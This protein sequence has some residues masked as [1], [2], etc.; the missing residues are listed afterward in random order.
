MEAYRTAHPKDFILL[1]FFSP[2][3]YEIRK[4]YPGADCICY[5]PL[6]FPWNARRF[7]QLTRP[8][9][10]YFVKYEF[11]YFFLTALKRR[12]IP[13]YLFSAIFLKEQP[14]F[15][16]YGGIYR[17]ILT[18][19]TRIFVQNPESEKLLHTLPGG[20][21]L[22]VTV[23]G[24]TRFDRVL[25]ICAE[26]RVPQNFKDFIQVAAPR[27]I[28]VAGSSWGD[29]EKHLVRLLDTYP[30]LQLVLA[31]HEIHAAHL[32]AI[33]GL[34][35]A[36][37]PVFFSQYPHPAAIPSSRV[38]VIDCM[39][40]LSSLYRYATLCY[41]GG[42]F[43]PSG[44]HNTLEAA[45]YG[46]PIL[47]GPNYNKFKEAMDLVAEGAVISYSTYDQLD[48]AAGTWLSSPQQAAAAGAAAAA[49]V[50]AHAGATQTILGA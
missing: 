36:H 28:L 37:K 6:D 44:I 40:L 2:S 18:C 42:G 4:N 16:W 46:K 13:T 29:D 8:S 39:G 48:K 22:P 14:F 21:R 34:F 35:A 33:A 15:K 7:L 11:W 47:I 38:L 19:Y 24:D 9:K 12:H 10:A 43:N 23:A 45:T 25:E 41:I 30:Q 1:T 49:Y 26:D 27:P 17:K 5:L 50:R 32:N 3:G 20:N 31:P